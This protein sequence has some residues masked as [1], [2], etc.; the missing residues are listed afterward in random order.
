MSRGYISGSWTSFCT[1]CG[2]PKG[3]NPGPGWCGLQEVGCR[4]PLQCA[5]APASRLKAH[6]LKAACAGNPPPPATPW[7]TSPPCSQ[8][9]GYGDVRLLQEHGDDGRH[10]SRRSA[11]RHGY[12]EAVS[13]HGKGRLTGRLFPADQTMSGASAVGCVC[14]RRVRRSGRVRAR[15][16]QPDQIRH[17]GRILRRGRSLFRHGP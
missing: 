2:R 4:P 11:Q 8:A 3:S 7:P 6:L 12:A 13:K 14:P 1:P 17:A 16:K 9:D 5:A 15:F 10:E